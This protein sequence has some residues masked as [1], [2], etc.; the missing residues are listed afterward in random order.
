MPRILFI[1][2]AG[3]L[4]GSERA[5]LDVLEAMPG[6]ELAVCTPTR[7]TLNAELAMRKIST[8]PCLE[9][10]LDKKSRWRR[11]LAALA[12]L[13]VCINVAPNLIVLN[14][15]GIYSV[16]LP[17]ASLLKIPIL[18]YVRIFED[19]AYL[20]RKRPNARRLRG[21]IAI[22]EAVREEIRH[23]DELSRI[24]HYQL[25]DA[26]SPSVRN[27][28]ASHQS[29]IVGGIAC[30]GRIVPGKGHDVLIRALGT[31]R[32]RG[33]GI[34]CFMV[35]DGEQRFIHELKEI[36]YGEGSTSL[37]EWTGYV[38]NVVE[39]LQKFNVL[40][41]PSYR[42]PLG[43]VIFEAWH[44]GA[45]PVVFSG[46]GGAAEIVEASQGG[47]MY[48]EQTPASLARALAEA[49]D[50]DESTRARLVRNGR[51]WMST[52]CSLETYTKHLAN[53]ISRSGH[54]EQD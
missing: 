43:R 38:R 25:Y 13:R 3:N 48:N 16:V 18:S 24:S 8:F 44:A 11:I 32:S 26:Y 41:C 14:Q 52:N 5:L 33:N 46:S 42:E 9:A 54:I 30:V 27:V 36:T 2:P 28:P 39:F 31:L 17:A 20:A 7:A 37:I 40:A 15:S 50:L 23:R 29:K 34:R 35:G 6:M 51:S 49:L 45:V 12:V 53:I 21:L 4:W 47:I 22:S 19:V 1:E 10:N